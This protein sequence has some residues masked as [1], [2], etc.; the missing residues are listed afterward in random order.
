LIVD[1]PQ[2]SCGGIKSPNEAAMS[3]LQSTFVGLKS[4]IVS[5]VTVWKSTFCSSA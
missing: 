2:K 5:L 1:F 4:W 3:K